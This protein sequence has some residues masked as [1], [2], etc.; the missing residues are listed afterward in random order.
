MDGDE[1]LV[2]HNPAGVE[3]PLE[4]EVGQGWYRYIGFIC[5][6]QQI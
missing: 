3:G 2:D 5:T 4:E 1:A 6:L